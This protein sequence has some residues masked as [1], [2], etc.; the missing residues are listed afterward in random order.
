MSQLSLF[1]A[2]DAVPDPADLEGV[3]AAR[4]Q[5][6]LVGD[7]AQVSVVV[8][9]PW[10]A[11]ALAGHLSAAG[12]GPVVSAPGEDGRRTVSTART[13]AL[14]PVVRRWRRG[15]VQ[16][17]PEGWTPSAGALRAWVI[18]SGRVVPGGAV[19]LGIDAA[20]EHHAPRRQALAAALER[21]GIRTTYVGVRGGGPLLRLGTAKARR[22]LAEAIG[23]APDGAPPGEWPG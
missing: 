18:T 13:G 19:D 10:R 3:L 8:D 23:A 15:A 11:D 6:T 21:A 7:V 16:A 22:R 2:D 4:G 12:L 1:A 9:A 17:V 14:T 20:L 5:S